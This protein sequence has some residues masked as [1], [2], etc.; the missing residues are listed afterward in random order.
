[1]FDTWQELLVGGAVLIIALAMVWGIVARGG[2]IKSKL[3]DVAGKPLPVKKTALTDGE[4]E[5]ISERIAAK[6]D[7]HKCQYRDI[8]A[9]GSA[10]FEPLAENVIALDDEAIERGKNGQIRTGRAKLAEKLAKFEAT[11]DGRVIA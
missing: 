11:R 9:A 4:I 3:F 1:M 7:D 10:M 2:R 6:L 5:R 8:I